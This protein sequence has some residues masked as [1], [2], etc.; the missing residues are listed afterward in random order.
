MAHNYG[1]NFPDFDTYLEQNRVSELKHSYPFYSDQADYNTNSKSYYDYLAHNNKL[2]QIL[3]KRIWEY[4]KEM[5]K[6]FEEWDKNLEEL[7]EDLE[8]LLIDWMK[9]GT[10]DDIINKNIFKDLNDKIETVA[11][12][13]VTLHQKDASQDTDIKRVDTKISTT[14][15]NLND[16]LDHIIS[17]APVDIVETV[18]ELNTK[19]KNGANGV[20]V[21]KSDG[22]YYYY[23]NNQW[24]KGNEYISPVTYALVK[25]NGSPTNLNLEDSWKT[26]PDIATL[27]T[28]FYTAFLQN[29][30]VNA[31]YPVA[32]NIPSQINGSICLIRVIKY[33]LDKNDT[34]T[35]FEIVEN[36]SSDIFRTS[37]TASGELM[38]WGTV[39]KYRDSRPLQ[40]YRLTYYDG[41]IP[42]L[43]V[44]DERNKNNLLSVPVTELPTGFYFGQIQDNNDVLDRLLPNDII[45]SPYYTF[46][47][48]KNYDNRI[49]ITL[50]D[51]LSKRTW[52]SYTLPNAKELIWNRLDKQTDLFEH[53]INQFTY[54]A[55]RLTSDKTFKTLIITDTHIEHEA[56]TNQIANINASNMDD[57]LKIDEGLNHND[58]SIH[59]GDFIDGNFD[60]PTSVSSAVKLCRDF[61]NKP[62]RYGIYG[63]HDYNGQW[64]GFSGKNGLYKYNLT[65]LFDKQDMK[66]YYTPTQKDY[67]YIDNDNKKTRLIFLNSFDISYKTKEDGQLYLDPLNTR[68]FGIV[69]IEWLLTTLDNVPQDYNVI[70]FTHDTF[71]NVFD[72]GQY[73]NGD[74]VRKICEAYQSK[75]ELEVFTTGIDETS[76]VY[77]YYKIEKTHSFENTKGKILSVV[78]GHRHIDKSL[79]KNGIRYISLLCARAESGDSEEKPIRNYYD[80]TRN[81]VS[82]LEFDVNNQI[83]K[84]MR[85]GAGLDRQYNMFK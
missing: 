28:G 3:A 4:D 46:N 12:D 51:N 8:N 22:Y 60:K 1:G 85:Y 34:R 71:N 6:R 77:D 39:L 21:V 50:H 56:K 19:Y 76:P 24:H 54:K 9:D 43:D 68:G 30:Q 23:Q 32:K 72:D 62:H 26:N 47:V 16:R 66:E 69:Q 33:G 78:N 27:S 36:S 49:S 52:Q 10:L 38:E 42:A 40:Q 25:Q 18:E 61:Y 59:L 83:V 75:T 48:Y 82:Y 13:N 5:A 31:N 35:D 15:R 64:D 45:Y 20:I 63:N 70:V 84:L 2:I 73:Y 80:I 7:P 81:A 53:D 11:A 67:Y 65:R 57:F 74:L 79:V 37:L 29:K 58:A 44:V 17:P 41:T 14:E 55:N